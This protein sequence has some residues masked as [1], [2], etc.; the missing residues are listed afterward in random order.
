MGGGGHRV[1]QIVQGVGEADQVVA[2]AGVGRE[3]GRVG[4]LEADPVGQAGIAGGL[5]GRGDHRVAVVEPG[6][7]RGR[8]PFGHHDRR[9]ALAAADV[10]DLAAGLQPA[11]HAVQRGDPAVDQCRTV[12]RPGE[13]RLG[14]VERGV[15]VAPAHPAAGP[16][17]AL[18]DVE[19]V[20]H[21]D[22]PG[23]DANQRRRAVVGGQHQ[24]HLVGQGE[25]A[26]GRVVPGVPGHG[27]A[28][29]PL[30]D[31]ALDRPRLGGQLGG[32]HRARTRHGRPQAQPVTEHD[33]RPGDGYAKVAEHLPDRLFHLLLVDSH[34]GLLPFR[35]LALMA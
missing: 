13:T 14:V 10:G 17:E 28:A 29:E 9:G 3:R 7:R 25:R 31:V 33:Q 5:A 34:Q 27:H 18:D 12:H 35:E 4:D 21:R 23:K 26:G 32:R 24:S 15:M 6:E 30:P 11:G 8:E 20:P 19:I 1:A 22:K 2:V 16:E